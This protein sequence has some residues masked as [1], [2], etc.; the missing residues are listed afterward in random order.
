MDNWEQ[1]M[2]SSSLGRMQVLDMIAEGKITAEEGA[3]LLEALQG[4][5]AKPVK[6]S[7]SPRIFSGEMVVIRVIDR[8]TGAVTVNLRLP[9]S[10]ISTARRL[11]A[12]VNT[13][14]Q[15]IDLEEILDTIQANPGE[16]TYRIDGEN[17][18]IEIMIE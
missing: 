15:H 6:A 9:Y 14:D 10:L 1:G 8:D 5:S 2:D 12:K 13:N 11:G 17:E 16:S 3:R 7:P 4:V 18:I